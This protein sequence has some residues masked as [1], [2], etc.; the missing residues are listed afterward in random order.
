M[1]LKIINL[2]INPY[3]LLHD[4]NLI[5]YIVELGCDLASD[6]SLDFLPLGYALHSVWLV[7]LLSVEDEFDFAKVAL[8]DQL[9]HDVLINFL[10]AIASLSR[11]HAARVLRKSRLV[12]IR[13]LI[14]CAQCLVLRNLDALI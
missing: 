14:E 12:V 5:H 2:S 7:V 13:G 6:Q 1:I 3:K 4:C 11:D 10:L 8:A 9:N